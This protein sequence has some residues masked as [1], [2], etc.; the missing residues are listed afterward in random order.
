MSERSEWEQTQTAF[1]TELFANLHREW[2]VFT[3]GV[4]TFTQ[5]AEEAG[6]NTDGSRD[7]SEACESIDYCL[8]LLFFRDQLGFE[9]RL[10][11]A[12]FRSI[13]AHFSFPLEDRLD[14]FWSHLFEDW[15]V[16][17]RRLLEACEML[18][19]TVPLESTIQPKPWSPVRRTLPRLPAA[20]NDTQAQHLVQYASNPDQA[21]YLQS[22]ANSIVVNSSA[23]SRQFAGSHSSE[24]PSRRTLH[25][26]G[27]RHTSDPSVATSGF[28]SR[29]INAL[30]PSTTTIP[31]ANEMFLLPQGY[32]TQ[33]DPTHDYF[34]D[35]QRG[36]YI[37]GWKQAMYA[38]TRK[39]SQGS[40]EWRP[41]GL[42]LL[43]AT[44]SKL[45]G[46]VSNNPWDEDCLTR[47]ETVQKAVNLVGNSIECRELPLF[48]WWFGEFLP[49]M[50]QLKE[51][52]RR[53]FYA[54]N[55]PNVPLL[56]TYDQSCRES[57]HSR[58]SV[59]PGGSQQL[60]QSS[61]TGNETN[62]AAPPPYEESLSL[63]SHR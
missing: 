59:L 42:L 50:N 2:Q 39:V 3:N 60:E 18:C 36:W 54:R 61:G 7:M 56:P 24:N 35:I 32:S 57:L 28:T 5:V 45:V 62:A 33:D 16:I 52:F 58:A 46:A 44:L 49:P 37:Q 34:N 27:D 17:E 41:D 10:T 63:T 12:H 47:A 43:K 29:T 40:D 14:L 53:S 23:R 51:E 48:E 11:A 19:I 21:R 22:V 1:A 25:G 8:A 55:R 6:C 4:G 31:G 20:L 38:I 15:K 13:Q 26:Q 30:P 9:I